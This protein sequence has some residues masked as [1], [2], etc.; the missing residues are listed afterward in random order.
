[1]FISLE[2]TI[3]SIA[4]RFYASKLNATIK[5]LEDEELLDSYREKIQSI[6][7]NFYV[8]SGARTITDIIEVIDNMSNEVEIVVI[9][10][11]QLV[12]GL[13]AQ[14]RVQEIGQITRLLKL[15]ALEKNIPILLL[16]QLNRQYDSSSPKLS[17]LRD[18]GCIEQDA[19]MVIFIIGGVSN[20]VL[21]ETEIR[22]LKN[23]R[24]KIGS[25]VVV[26]NKETQRWS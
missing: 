3:Q 8:E 21:A 18:S 7:C 26:F 11:L 17:N 19:D 12:E 15:K 10:Y 25:A 9:D 24:G 20:D 14:T 2:M 1:M 16:S 5:E 23:R 13:D 6:D 4:K 22:V